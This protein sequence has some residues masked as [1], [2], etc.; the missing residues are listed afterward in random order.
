M[1]EPLIWT[2]KGNLLIADLR[3]ETLWNDSSD[4]TQ[5]TENY[6]LGDE[7]VKSSSHVYSRKPLEAQADQGFLR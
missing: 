7:L 5:F 2:S 1:Q 3:Y 6:Y 4:F